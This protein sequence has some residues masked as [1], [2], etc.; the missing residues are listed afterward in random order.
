M[1][2]S[3]YTSHQFLSHDTGANHPESPERIKILIDL[4]NEEFSKIP[5][6]E[7]TPADIEDIALTH[8]ESYIYEIMDS[9]PDIGYRAADTQSE[10]VLSPSSWES[11][12]LSAG[13]GLS[14]L[15]HIMN[16]DISRAFCATRPP[17]HHANAT[18]PMGFCFFNNAFI[19]AR[20]A[21]E[22]FNLKRIAII[23]FDVHH[24]NGTDDLTRTHNTNNPE[25]PIFYASSHQYP[26]WPMSGIE[27]DNTDYII[28]TTIQEG[29]NGEVMLKAYEENIF[30]ALNAYTPELLII[31]AGFDAHKDDPLAGLTL[32]SSDFGALTKRICSIANQHSQNRVISMLEGGYN[33]NALKD[34]VREHLQSLSSL[35][36]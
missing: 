25:N 36:F 32:D 23:D 34:S 6:I 20:T 3:I 21:Q 9:I 13:A 17:G 28:N 24:G 29:A 31:S 27:Q 16:G 4:F 7:P 33:L 30:P 12:T 1:K 8:P 11:I 5:Q 19:T 2:T 14:A 26:L 22:R 15:Q 10:C 18:N 35:N